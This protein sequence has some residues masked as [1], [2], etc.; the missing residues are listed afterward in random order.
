MKKALSFLLTA[1]MLISCFVMSVGADSSVGSDTPDLG[2][3]ARASTPTSDIVYDLNEDHVDPQGVY[4]TLDGNTM[5]AVV[6]KN[7]YSDS[8]SAVTGDITSVIIPAGVRIGGSVYAVT[9]VGRNAF[10]GSS[11]KS[12]VIYCDTIG[13]FAFAGCTEL[14]SVYTYA[15]EIRGFAF[16]GCTA[17]NEANIFFAE[18]IGGGAFWGCS[19]LN[20]L[21]LIDTQIIMDK[22]FEGCD[23][24]RFIVFECSS[25][26]AA[27]QIAAGAVPEGVKA[28]IFSNNSEFFVDF[29]LE[30]V[31]IEGS[32]INVNDVYGEAGQTVIVPVTVPFGTSGESSMT[33]NIAAAAG[34]TVT[35]IYDGSDYYCIMDN[36]TLS[37][38]GT[39]FSGTNYYGN[40][41]TLVYLEVKLDSDLAAGSYIITVRSDGFNSVAGAV[42]VCAHENTK[43]LIQAASTC[44]EDG[45]A[46]T[47]CADCGKLIKSG[48]SVPA[49][50][51][52]YR[53][54]VIAPTCGEGGYTRHICSTCVH[55]YSD[56]ETEAL[57]HDWDDGVVEVEA[58]TSKKGLI[59]YTCKTCAAKNEVEIPK[60]CKHNW[61]DG[62]VTKK[63]TTTEEGVLT[64]TCSKCNETKEEP[65]PV[66]LVAPGDVNGDGDIN[67]ADVTLLL[68]YLASWEV[69]VSEAA[70]VNGDDTITLADATLLLK[71]LAGW[72]VTLG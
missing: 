1:A 20:T 59:V 4:Y 27:P 36:S 21:S 33:C 16:W 54:F 39:S 46:D 6:G 23:A 48:V 35:G 51:H 55:A 22:A 28:Y 49:K 72:D 43:T 26:E 56:A 32:V 62:V 30:V 71:H 70:D 67:L 29:P 10:D 60:L 50:E 2:S 58:S 14:K 38:D 25:S 45:I 12:A 18:T 61:D 37:S 47:V 9:A 8:A 7:T 17:L 66:L 42:I 65:I 40:Y 64:Y 11:V 31:I 5:T 63:P 24:L 44:T 3:A 57:G 15:T 34:L 41:L 19:M 68:K 53:D 69:T 13:E 52:S